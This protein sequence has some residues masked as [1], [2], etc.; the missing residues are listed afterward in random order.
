MKNRKLIFILPFFV[1]RLVV[2]QDLERDHI[3]ET[4]S[5]IKDSLHQVDA[6]NRLAMLMYERNADS[7]FYYARLAKEISVRHNYHK[8]KAD[9]NN[10][11]GVFFDIQGNFHLALKYYN[12]GLVDYR[13]LK[14]SSNMVQAL[15]NIAMVYTELGNKKESTKHF[16]Q[17]FGYA[18]LLKKDSIKSLLIYNYL[19]I[20][21]GKFNNDQTR[22]YIDQAKRIAQKYRDQR[23]LLAIDQLVADQYI[24]NG[25][26]KRGIALLKKTITSAID[27]ELFY[28]SMDMLID[29]G[30]QVQ[31]F[32][33]EQSASY[34]KKALEIAERHEY[35]FYSR[36]LM[37]KLFDYYVIKTDSSMA[38]FYGRKLIETNDKLENLTS[39][40]NIDYIDYVLK[41]EQIKSLDSRYKYQLVI[42]GMASMA[43]VLTG[44]IIIFI[45]VNLRK[46]R[47]QNRKLMNAL[48]ALE[49]SNEANTNIMRIVAHDLRDPLGGMSTALKV[50]E[51][52]LG[53]N[54]EN[55]SIL[56]LM[57]I[58][59]G[60]AL[61]LTENLLHQQFNSNDLPK[62]TLDMKELLSYCVNLLEAKAL[63]KNQIISLK[64]NSK[65][66]IP[67][68]SD[69]LWRVF[70]NLITNAIKFGPHGSK[71]D[72]TAT[73]KE[74][75]I[76]V[77][78][79]DVGA[80]IPEEF[81]EEIFSMYNNARNFG[82]AGEKS[83]GM[84][85]A[86]TKRIVEMHNG[87]I[88]FTN[89]DGPGTTFYVELPI[90]GE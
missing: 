38:L 78:I 88:W 45:L 1:I 80:G 68:Y 74:S 11:F 9:A 59:I 58:S 63:A 12:L 37:R 43:L 30:Q 51:Q 3:Q 66:L 41:E 57:K 54:V 6:I 31:E 72:I 69:Q 89:N 17:A 90:F 86:I 77:A 81:S 50:M 29:L 53:S 35:L 52:Q 34:Y 40:K 14:D 83:F 8:G 2:A 44:I 4:L 18:N 79:K 64:S 55:R 28:V 24:H 42:S 7:T 46:R 27:K 36:L 56:Q 25:E 47:L 60:N 26:K 33:P 71:I 85:L 21:P 67:A 73:L 32:A 10:N 22:L 61:H 75:N 19:L 82:T 84:G 13:K 49:S 87:R 76:L 48:A 39:R 62:E 65:I 16:D 5:Q 23:T 20:H 70:S 15:M